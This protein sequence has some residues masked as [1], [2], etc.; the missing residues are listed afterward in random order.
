MEI[1]FHILCTDKWSPRKG[2]G[3]GRAC[4]RAELLS[5]QV[6]WSA[7]DFKTS[8]KQLLGSCKWKK[9]LISL[10]SSEE[11]LE[12]Q[13]PI[14]IPHPR[15]KAPNIKSKGSKGSTRIFNVI[16]RI[17]YLNSLLFSHIHY[18]KVT[19]Y[20]FFYFCPSPE[21]TLQFY[22][23]ITAS[24]LLLHIPVEQYHRLTSERT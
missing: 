17:T 8:N 3:A 12:I 21:Q 18:K 13:H 2:H 6:L 1:I 10:L 14:Y 5:L 16:K 22:S 19:L 11:G 24:W 20:V 7:G 4:Y 9:Q 23:P 15:S